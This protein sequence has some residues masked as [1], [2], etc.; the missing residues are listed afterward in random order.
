MYF[1]EEQEE[2][3]RV[4]VNSFADVFRVLLDE[5]DLV[6]LYPINPNPPT[7]TYWL[8]AELP[9]FKVSRTLVLPVDQTLEDL[10][11]WIQQAFD[12]DN[13]HL[14]KFFMNPRNPYNGEQYYDPRM[15][16]GWA[17]GYP[18]D[19]VTLA[20]LALYAGQRFLYIFDFG[21]R[22]EFNISVVRQRP[23][24]PSTQARVE[25]VVGKA[26]AQYGDDEDDELD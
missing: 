23:D 8:R 7:G 4:P 24:D 5:P 18:A 15:E 25:E 11:E 2:N 14:Y 12:F 3:E 21:D 26:P 22:W 17:D 16:E 10:H 9:N 1:D 19:N 13:D 6:S 20:D